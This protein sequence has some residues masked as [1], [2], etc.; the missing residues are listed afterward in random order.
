VTT[1]N[2]YF[3]L[4]ALQRVPNLGAASAKKLIR[5]LGSAEAVFKEPKSKL[6]KIDGI[7]TH[8]IQDLD[9]SLYLNEAEQELEFINKNQIKVLPFFDAHYPEKLKH[10][11]DGPLLLFQRGNVDLQNKKIISIVGTRE[12]TIHGKEFCE[13]L[14]ADLAPLA[15]VIV[16]G[17]A[18][19]ADITAHLAAVKNGLQTVACLGHGMNQCYPRGH[20]KYIKEIEVNGGF[21]TEFWSGDSFVKTN[22]LQ[23]N[24]IIAGL[25]EATI[26]IESAERG[27]SLVTADI[28]N[29]YNREVFA[30]PGRTTDSMSAGCNNLI[31]SQQAHLLTSAA[32]LVYLLNWDVE[33]KQ[34]KEVQ[35]QLFVELTDEEKQLH[36]YLSARK[37]EMIDII[38]LECQMPT[39]KAAMLLLNLEL[40][41]VVR[42]LPGKM[43][44]VI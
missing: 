36:D 11:Q 24:R 23:R 2:E 1:A 10:C 22:F 9:S 15:P 8:K 18:L 4:L 3:Y 35:K 13:K 6:L 41:G 20:K 21:L 16:S 31:K 44:E 12:L 19:G 5:I 7:G 39:H 28:A 25:S 30:V 26:V 42:P 29:S 27:G 14:I 40:K 17:F 37:K 33:E 34:H 38:A 43:F 32:D